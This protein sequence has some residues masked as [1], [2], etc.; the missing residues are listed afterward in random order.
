MNFLNIIK[1]V[2]K[3]NLA[4]FTEEQKEAILVQIEAGA[5]DG[6]LSH[7]MVANNVCDS[8]GKFSLPI[9]SLIY[10]TDCSQF[11][12]INATGIYGNEI[13]KCLFDST[14]REYSIDSRP[15]NNVDMLVLL[16]RV[17]ERIPLEGFMN[18]LRSNDVCLND[19]GLIIHPDTALN[20]LLS[21]DVYKD[22]SEGDIARSFGNFDWCGSNGLLAGILV[23]IPYQFIS[24]VVI[25]EEL[26][27]NAD[28]MNNLKTYFPTAYVVTEKGQILY[29]N[30]NELENVKAK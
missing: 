28:V 6:E 21:Y 1:G 10:F 9:G 4:N 12:L 17:N 14:K 5:L 13:Y 24:G 15:I 2:L 8:D 11:K 25:S 7:K 29:Q 3:S 27:K 23:G 19:V 16:A 20:D 26:S 30:I 22:T 18:K